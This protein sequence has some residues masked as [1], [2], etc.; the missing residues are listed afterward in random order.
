MAIASTCSKKLRQ[1]MKRSSKRQSTYK[2][3]LKNTMKTVKISALSPTSDVEKLVNL[4][5]NAASTFI[6]IE[7]FCFALTFLMEENL[8]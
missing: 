7:I 4:L 6:Q 3:R 1:P 8:S 5:K 2:K